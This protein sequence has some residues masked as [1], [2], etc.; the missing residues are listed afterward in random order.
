MCVKEMLLIR[1]HV[2]VRE[3]SRHIRMTSAKVLE[4]GIVGCIQRALMSSGAPS[5]GDGAYE[6]C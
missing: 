5:L 4:R 3:L 2:V 1:A 6:S